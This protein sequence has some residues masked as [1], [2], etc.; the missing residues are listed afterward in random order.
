MH[1][2]QV[3]LS[4]STKVEDKLHEARCALS[5]LIDHV[6]GKTPLSSLEIDQMKTRVLEAVNKV[7]T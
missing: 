5:A 3:R 4:T 1:W 7:N 6:N 2:F